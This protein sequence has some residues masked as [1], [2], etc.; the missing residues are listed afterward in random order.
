MR[1]NPSPNP[2]LS[3]G[4]LSTPTDSFRSPTKR[5]KCSRQ[6]LKRHCLDRRIWWFLP[7]R[8]QFRELAKSFSNKRLKHV[9]TKWRW[10]RNFRPWK[11]T[12]CFKQLQP[13]NPTKD[14]KKPSVN[15]RF[16]NLFDLDL[17]ISP[18]TQSFPPF[19]AATHKSSVEANEVNQ[20][21]LGVKDLPRQRP[22][23]WMHAE[24][25]S[26]LFFKRLYI[27]GLYYFI[28]VSCCFLWVGVANG[29]SWVLMG[30]LG[31]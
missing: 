15:V 5:R 3:L 31:C 2:W 18:T 7:P 29:I 21:I 25:K 24:K 16:F 8:N 19:Q 10:I 14:L 26:G 27:I 20:R 13:H 12:R 11:K 6:L 17:Q 30:F 4:V 22:G 28:G 9:E 1:R 23:W